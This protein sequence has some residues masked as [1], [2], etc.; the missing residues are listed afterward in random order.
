MTQW[1]LECFVSSSEAFCEGFD[2]SKD[3]GG[4]MLTHYLR[5]G[6]FLRTATESKSLSMAKSAFWISS[7]LVRFGASN[8]L[9][10]PH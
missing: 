3:L 5:N 10:S 9:A 2:A 6:E 1:L 8:F 4:K 7:I